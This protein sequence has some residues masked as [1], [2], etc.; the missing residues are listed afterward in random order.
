[1]A[2]G[3]DYHRLSGDEHNFIFDELIVPMY[4]NNITPQEAPV[5]P[6]VM[7]PQGAGKSY[8]AR[9]LRRVLRARPPVQIDPTE[10]DDVSGCNMETS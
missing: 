9:M 5:V 3:V 1:M 7:G 4:L 10:S 8:T 6:Y 2:P